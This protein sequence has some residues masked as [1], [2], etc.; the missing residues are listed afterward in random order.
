MIF[1]KWTTLQEM[2]LIHIQDRC[3]TIRTH[4]ADSIQAGL[5][6]VSA[7]VPLG[8]QT[9]ATP[10]GRYA[11]TP[12][13]DGVSPSAGKDVNGPTAAASS[14]AKLDHFIVSNGTLFNQ[15]FH[16]SALCGT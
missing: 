6:P 9:G 13:A 16:P 5:Y 2:W 14:V 11:H 7:N 4:E 1:R 15:K 12:V 8:G 3:R 10:D